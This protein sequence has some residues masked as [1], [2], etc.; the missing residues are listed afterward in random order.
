MYCE[1]YARILNKYLT[2]HPYQEKPQLNQMV[3]LLRNWQNTAADFGFHHAATPHSVTPLHSYIEGRAP[4]FPPRPLRLLS[5]ARPLYFARSSVVSY[6]SPPRSLLGGGVVN[7][8]CTPTPKVH[9]IRRSSLTQRRVA[10]KF[11]WPDTCRLPRPTHAH[12]RTRALGVK[13]ASTPRSY[14][15]PRVRIGTVTNATRLHLDLRHAHIHCM[16]RRLRIVASA[17]PLP[18]GILADEADVRRNA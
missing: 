13:F 3:S 15:E 8:S 12:L 4:G 9:P 14:S 11:P 5:S 18:P 16:L 7:C 6:S 17:I 10:N 2:D 1:A